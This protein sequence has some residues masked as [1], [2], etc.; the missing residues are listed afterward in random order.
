MLRGGGR[1]EWQATGD[2]RTWLDEVARCKTL[3]KK[4]ARKERFFPRT[5][6]LDSTAPFGGCFGITQKW[7][8]WKNTCLRTRAMLDITSCSSGPWE[9]R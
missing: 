1:R 2:Y 9:H 7:N 6:G 5:A 8:R 4:V 3:P